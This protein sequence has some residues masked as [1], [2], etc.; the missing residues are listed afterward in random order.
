MAKTPPDK[1]RKHSHQRGTQYKD[2]Q[3]CIVCGGKLYLRG[4]YAH[5]GM[6]GP[7]CTGDAET[8]QE[9]GKTW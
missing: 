3:Q 7:C 2:A 8:A 5:T 9:A 6:C 1:A 4:G